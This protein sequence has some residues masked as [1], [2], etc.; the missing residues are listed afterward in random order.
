MIERLYAN[1]LFA[2]YQMSI[3]LSIMMLPVALLTRHVGI[4]PPVHRLVERLGNA[5][6]ATK[7]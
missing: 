2:L 6:D 7:A 3:M 5:Y 1:A 4:T